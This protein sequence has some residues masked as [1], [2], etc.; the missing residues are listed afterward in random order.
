MKNLVYLFLILIFAISAKGEIIFSD[1]FE[2]GTLDKWIVNGRQGN[3]YVAEVVTR[4][5]SQ[6]AHLYKKYYH[7]ITIEKRFDY[8]SNLIFNF[9][10]EVDP[11]SEA[12]STSEHYSFGGIRVSFLDSSETYMGEVRYICSTSS[13]PFEQF[14]PSPWHYSFSIP[15]NVGMVSYSLYVQDLLSNID[16]DEG[17]ISYA[18]LEFW[19]YS[20]TDFYETY[21]DT[22]VDNVVV[23]PEPGTLILLGLGTFGLWRNRRR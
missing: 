2:D 10:M 23:I 12:S 7:E 19:A 22:W 6:M 13:W 16:I 15:E 8:N 9:D 5:M 18:N 4:H 21:A 3:I 14:N 11:Y 17:S 1:D 20:S